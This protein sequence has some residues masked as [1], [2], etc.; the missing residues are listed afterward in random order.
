MK[1]VSIIFCL[2]FSCGIVA[3]QV[4]TENPL[5]PKVTIE[6]AR[7]EDNFSQLA[8][9]HQY[10]PQDELI[11]I[12][13]HLGENEKKDYGKRRLHNARTFLTQSS[14]RNRLKEYV[15]AVEGEKVEGRGY[16]DFYVKGKIEL[17]IYF[18]KNSDLYAIWCVKDRDEKPCEMDGAK[19]YY[20][21]KSKIKN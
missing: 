21:C 6:T 3:A 20:P 13:S 1:T 9:L 11:I 17:R 7:C 16:L 5:K 12:I 18:K 14:S 10:T 4:K 19:L 15:L 2:L 8:I